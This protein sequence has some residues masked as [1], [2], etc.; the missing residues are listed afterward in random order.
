MYKWKFLLEINVDARSIRNHLNKETNKTSR[1]KIHILDYLAY[2]TSQEGN[3]EHAL[4]VIQEIL[5]ITSNHVR[6]NNYTIYYEIV[7]ENRTLTK[8]ERKNDMNTNDKQNLKLLPTVSQTKNYKRNNARL[9]SYFQEREFYF[10]LLACTVLIRNKW[11]DERG[12]AFRR[13]CVTRF[14]GMSES[15][16]GTKLT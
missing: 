14:N 15:S 10:L 5:T 3:I 2:T 1:I 8:Q 9:D 7:I 11:I 13:S 4:A 6:T 16:V 12:E